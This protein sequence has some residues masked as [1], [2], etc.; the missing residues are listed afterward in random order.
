MNENKNRWPSRKDLQQSAIAKRN[1]HLFEKSQKPAAGEKAIGPGTKLS[2]YKSHIDTVV[3]KYAD[4]K[5]VTL[6]REFKFHPAMK[7]RFDWAFL[8]LKVA[9]EYEGIFS[10]KSR[11][12]T[13]DGYS[14]DTEKYNY[15]ASLGWEVRRYTSKTYLNIEND[16]ATL[17]KRKK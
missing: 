10:E 2:K 5:G 17:K 15:A 4:K 9:I 11:H 8:E 13:L 1:P 6:Y 3:E 16:L 12:T 14:K 7:F